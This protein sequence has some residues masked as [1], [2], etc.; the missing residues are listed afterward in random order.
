ML[1]AE[2]NY[3]YKIYSLY[4]LQRTHGPSILSPRRGWDLHRSDAPAS[5][6]VLPTDPCATRVSRRQSG[7]LVIYARRRFVGRYAYVNPF[8]LIGTYWLV[9]LSIARIGRLG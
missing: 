4:Y 5:A 9:L 3:Y 2:L 1:E 7:P 8:S 6:C